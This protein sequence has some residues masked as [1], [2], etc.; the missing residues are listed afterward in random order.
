M[1]VGFQNRSWDNPAEKTRDT[2]SSV[3]PR[4][5]SVVRI[6]NAVSE[7]GQMFFFSTIVRGAKYSFMMSDVSS[8]AVT[9][10]RMSGIS[11]DGVS[12]P[13][14]A[15]AELVSR[16]R[17]GDTAAFER[18]VIENER[19][20]LAVAWRMLGRR[21]EAED[22]AQEV[23]LRAYRFL[24]R[25]DPQRPLTPWLLRITV[26]VCHDLRRRGRRETTLENEHG[27][28][29]VPEPGRGPETALAEDER[30]RLLW[31]ALDTLPEK[32]RAAIVLRDLEGLSTNEVAEALESSPATVRSQI[33]SARLKIR[34]ALDRLKVRI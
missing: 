13:H 7:I 33:S 27:A 31:A 2:Q 10:C 32:E 4:T 19:R 6:R 8:S 14:T 5:G 12:R 3:R 18:I 9:A 21:D 34:K 26:N 30:R 17:S 22:A 29:Q 11:G 25:V 23:F 24:H 20:V 15:T 28:A 1:R 16:A